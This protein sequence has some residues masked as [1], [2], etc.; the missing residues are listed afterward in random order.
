MHDSHPT[1][2]AN[3]DRSKVTTLPGLLVRY[4]PI[5]VEASCNEL[6]PMHIL[7]VLLGHCTD[8]QQTTCGYGNDLH[9]KI[10]AGCSVNCGIQSFEPVY[11]KVMIR[12]QPGPA[13]P[14]WHSMLLDTQRHV[15]E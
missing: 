14:Q 9:T 3:T 8:Q 4:L 2:F 12:S 10:T 1:R 11:P 13:G 5:L 7:H 6:V 15:C